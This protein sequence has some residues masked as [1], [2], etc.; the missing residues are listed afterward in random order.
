MAVRIIGETG[1]RAARRPF[2]AALHP[3]A[4]WRPIHLGLHRAPRDVIRRGLRRIDRLVVRRAG[5]VLLA[6]RRVDRAEAVRQ[7]HR[8]DHRCF[9]LEQR[10]ASLEAG[11]T[12]GA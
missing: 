6:L 7:V 9:E 5:R 10:L 2:A 12:D 4:R 8:L 11:A 3:P 1:A